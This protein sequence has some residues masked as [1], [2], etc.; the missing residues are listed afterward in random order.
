M[1]RFNY[2]KQQKIHYLQ[3]Q[4]QELRSQP[5]Y[6]NDYSDHF[7]SDFIPSRIKR[8]SDSFETELV[9]YL[10]IRNIIIYFKI[11]LNLFLKFDL[12]KKQ[13]ILEYKLA[14]ADSRQNKQ[15]HNSVSY[16]RLLK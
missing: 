12:R 16:L 6:I 8:K 4:L 3:I 1:E 7:E 13:N 2:E 14:F 10:F 15:A 5:S 9:I 11:I